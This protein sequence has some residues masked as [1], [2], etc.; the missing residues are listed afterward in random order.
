MLSRDVRR[1][2]PDRS[3]RR[4]RESRPIPEND[5]HP[6]LPRQAPERQKKTAKRPLQVDQVIDLNRKFPATDLSPADIPKDLTA[7]FVG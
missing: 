5:S 6:L 3:D 1:Q 2:T 7:T 4:S